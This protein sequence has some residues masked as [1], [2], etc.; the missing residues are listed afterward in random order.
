MVA[1]FERMAPRER[2]ALLAWISAV[3]AV[4]ALALG[5]GRAPQD[6]LYSPEDF[7]RCDPSRAI[8]A[9]GDVV[10]TALMWTALWIT[11]NPAATRLH[12]FARAV[13]AL[14]LPVA[15]IGSLTAVIGDAYLIARPIAAIGFGALG[16]ALVI[17]SERGNHLVRSRLGMVLGATLSV[18][19]IA[20]VPRD[21]WILPTGG[22]LIFVPYVIWAVRMGYR[23]ATDRAPWA[24]ESRPIGFEI[25]GDLAAVVLLFIASPFWI[26]STFGVTSL[27]DRSNF[28]TVTNATGEPIFFY[29]DRRVAAYRERIEAG[30]AKTLDWLEHGTYPTAAENLGGMKIYCRDLLDRELRRAHYKITVV[31]DPTT[32]ESR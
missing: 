2:A 13:G 30:E 7:A 11:R 26:T 9:L 21:D 6:C 31:R 29:D 27:G 15:I 16:F 23:L 24:K 28:V 19:A 4:G 17:E 10:V 20:Y 8:G 32:C 3:V 1:W 14:G 22:T 25:V 12:R 5:Y 18:W